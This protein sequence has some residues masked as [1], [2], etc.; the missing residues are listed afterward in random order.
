[1]SDLVAEFGPEMAAEMAV[2]K[3]R[4]AAYAPPAGLAGLSDRELDRLER[5]E[6]ADWM[7]E[8][9]DGSD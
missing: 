3:Q 1:M 2:I 9:G 4:L 5:Q 6:K 7:T 8:N